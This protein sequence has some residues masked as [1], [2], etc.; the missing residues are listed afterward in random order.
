MDLR[1]LSQDPTP[2]PLSP[3]RLHRRG[4]PAYSKS[5]NLPPHFPHPPQKSE[6]PIRPHLCLSFLSGPTQATHSRARRRLGR[7]RVGGVR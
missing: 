7:G 4:G 3:V 5:E 6:I 1:A 2:R